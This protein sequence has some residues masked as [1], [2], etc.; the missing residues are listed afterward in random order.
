METSAETVKLAKEVINDIF[1]LTGQKTDLSE[2]TVAA[3]LIFS[4]VVRQ[5]GADASAEIKAAAVDLQKAAQ[6]QTATKQD[7]P[8]RGQATRPPQQETTWLK[9][10]AKIGT[11]V[12]LIA[13]GAAVGAGTARLMPLS[14]GGQA[15]DLALASQVKHQLA[16]E[17]GSGILWRTLRPE[18]QNAAIAAIGH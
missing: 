2:P 17:G 6:Q 16:Q 8:N 9:R 11:A 3:A 1:T 12:V 7:T 15:L 18:A 10:W 13:V 4:R 14:Y 5:A